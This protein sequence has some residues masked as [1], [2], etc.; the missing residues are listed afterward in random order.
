MRSLRAP[1]LRD[2]LVVKSRGPYN[3]TDYFVTVRPRRDGTTVAERT[4][5][6]VLEG[7]A[8]VADLLQPCLQESEIVRAGSVTNALALLRDQRFDAFCADPTDPAL[9][10]QAGDL[11]RAG[12]LLDALAE[13]VAVV[14]ADLR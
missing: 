8:R 12:R 11:T 2:R 4:R 1:A 6:L 7:G 14:G 3:S 10:E 5:I 13:G 9:R